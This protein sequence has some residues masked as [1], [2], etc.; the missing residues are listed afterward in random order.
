MCRACIPRHTLFLSRKAEVDG[1]VATG[2][3]AM[4]GHDVFPRMKICHNIDRQFLALMF[5]II[6]SCINNPNPIDVDFSPIIM[7][8]FHKHILQFYILRQLNCSA[9]PYVIGCPRS[10]ASDFAK[11]IAYHHRFT[12]GVFGCKS[13]ASDTPRRIIIIRLKPVGS[14][15]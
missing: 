8:I 11:L 12:I 3:S 1:T 2:V 14:R 9:N 13:S 7:G 5:S 15:C 4:N 10:V 6:D